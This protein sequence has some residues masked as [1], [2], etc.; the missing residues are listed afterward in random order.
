VFAGRALQDRNYIIRAGRISVKVF[1]DVALI[2]MASNVPVYK[3][4]QSKGIRVAL[5]PR[6]C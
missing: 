4:V 3:L 6:I 1:V 5:I 2:I